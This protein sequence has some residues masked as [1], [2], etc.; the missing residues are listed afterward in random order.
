MNLWI[1]EREWEGEDAFLIG[2]GPSLDRFDF[3]QLEGLNTIG[4]ND[5][6][7]LGNIIQI[8]IFGDRMWWERN[9][10]NLEYFSGRLVTNAPGLLG[11]NLPNVLKMTRAVHGLH[12]GSVLGWNYSTGAMAINLAVSLGASGIFLLGY[13]LVNKQG[14]SHWHTYNPKTIREDSYDRFL[15]GFKKVKEC[16]PEGVRVVNVTDGSSRVDCFEKI[17]FETFQTV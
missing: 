1:P 16:L 3:S 4:C 9:K 17:D 7:R 8:C 10:H 15:M 11:Y 13:D 5:A 2:G 6:F 14:R 12:S